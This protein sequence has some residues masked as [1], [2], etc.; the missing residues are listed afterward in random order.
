M[1]HVHQ[2]T[3]EIYQTSDRLGAFT[4]DCLS[5]Y[6]CK[7]DLKRKTMC[8]A[9]VSVLKMMGMVCFMDK[10]KGLLKGER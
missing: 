1:F 8:T 10:L 4:C 6:L 9:C 3:F 2:N 5:V 7:L